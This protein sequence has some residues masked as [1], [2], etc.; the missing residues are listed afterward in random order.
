M[1]RLNPST[2]FPF[3]QGDVREDG[4]TFRGYSSRKRSDGQQYENW[5]SPKMCFKNSIRNCYWNAKKRASEEGYAFDLDI[6]YLLSIYPEDGLCPVL[7]TSMVFGEGRWST[8][9]LDKFNPDLGYVRGNVCW[10]GMKAN[11]LKSDVTDP[12][13]FDAIAKY[14]RHGCTTQHTS[15]LNNG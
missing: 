3:V 13:V 7:K 11:F 1:K 5:M 2:G 12:V 6:P 4:Y 9:S 15:N 8:P 14:M 10:I